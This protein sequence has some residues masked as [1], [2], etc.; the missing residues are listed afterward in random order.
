MSKKPNSQNG[1]LPHRQNAY[2]PAITPAWRNWQT[3]WTQNP[4]AA[5]PCGFEPLRRQGFCSTLDVR[6]SAFEGVNGLA[7]ASRT[8]ALT[9]FSAED[10]PERFRGYSGAAEN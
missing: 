3:R 2:V 4:V 1:C 9:Q 10:S 8:R 7:A 6:C 5:R